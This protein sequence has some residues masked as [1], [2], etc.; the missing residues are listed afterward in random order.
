MIVF[1]I[2]GNNTA[3]T[4]PDVVMPRDLAEWLMV[5]VPSASRFLKAFK[6]TRRES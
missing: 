2:N 1:K 3:E 4:L 5:M 6:V